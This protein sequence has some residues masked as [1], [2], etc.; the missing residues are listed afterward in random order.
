[1]HLRN[2]RAQRDEQTVAADASHD[3]IVF[4]FH[5]FAPE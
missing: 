3:K 5:D 2:P 1:M 4:A